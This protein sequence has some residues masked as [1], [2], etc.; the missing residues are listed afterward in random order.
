[1]PKVAAILKEAM[2]EEVPVQLRTAAILKVKGELLGMALDKAAEEIPDKPNAEVLKS[3]KTSYEQV[4]KEFLSNIE[5]RAPQVQE[6]AKR[7]EAEIQGL[8]Q[9]VQILEEELK[10]A[11][12]RL[13]AVQRAFED[14]RKTLTDR[15][16]AL[17]EENKKPLRK[18]EII[19]RVPQDAPRDIKRHAPAA[20][21]PNNKCM[22]LGQ[23]KDTIFDI[24][25]QKIKYDE[26][27]VANH[28]SKETMEQ[29]MYTYL[30]QVYGLKNLIIEAAGGIIQGI[31]KHSVSDSDV[32]SVSYTHLTLPTIC[33]V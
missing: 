8:T 32:A 6:D 17:E 14:E 3:I 26:K 10:A 5:Y 25:Q 20:A 29:Y 30:N 15:I 31:K 13:E 9:A 24:Y 27:C 12:G 28:Q 11:N 1:M 18:Y 2:Q 4:I 21:C 19:S 33:S 7:S 23:L 16:A 22:P